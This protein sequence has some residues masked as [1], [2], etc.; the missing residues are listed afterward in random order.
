VLTGTL[1]FWQPFLITGTLA[2]VLLVALCWGAYLKRQLG[3]YTGDAL[4][5]SVVLSELVLLLF[6]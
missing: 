6:L 3:G 1:S 2:A 4:G 5:A